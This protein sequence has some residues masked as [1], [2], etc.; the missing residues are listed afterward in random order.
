MQIDVERR[1]M[2]FFF[3][4]NFAI[5]AEVSWSNTS[6]TRNASKSHEVEGWISTC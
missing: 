3:R 4:D 1:I 5:L 6:C 2:F